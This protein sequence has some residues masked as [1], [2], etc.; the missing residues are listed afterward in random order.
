[1]SVSKPMVAASLVMGGLVAST[2]VAGAP[3]GDA[4]KGKALFA[5]CAIC[6]DLNPGVQKMGPNLHG[7]FGRKAGTV[8]GFNYSPAMK[9]AKITWSPTTLDSYVTSP[10]KLVPGNKMAFAGLAA[11][12]DRVNL[13][14]YLQS[15]T[16]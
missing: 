1:M 3:A 15:A 10:A 5:R 16:K 7:L 4:V 2:A 12:A 14:A 11:P 6:H 13:I 8:A 9:S